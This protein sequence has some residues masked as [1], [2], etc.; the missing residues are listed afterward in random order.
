MIASTSFKETYCQKINLIAIKS[1]CRVL[2][3]AD[4]G[5]GLLA[6]TW[7]IGKGNTKS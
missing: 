3:R 1:D 6:S 2:I 4:P 5:K 7:R